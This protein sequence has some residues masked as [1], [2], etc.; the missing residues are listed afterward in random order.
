MNMKMYSERVHRSLLQ[1]ASNIPVF[2]LLLITLFI[3]LVGAG[4]CIARVRNYATE[5]EV[6]DRFFPGAAI[7]ERTIVLTPQMRK[8]V[9]SLTRRRFFWKKVR[10]H[11]A[12]K[13]GKVLGYAAVVNETG[14]TRKI[15]FM[16]LLDPTGEVKG[17]ELLVFRESQGYEIENPRW[18]RQFAGK[19]ID[20]PLR[21]NRDIVAISGATLSARAVTRGVKRVLAVFHVAGNLLR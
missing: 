4:S 3:L 9:E 6:L 18:R 13:E 11:I 1:G 5:D 21:L 20:D 14:K 7:E 2:R 17:V 12:R 19:T 8:E 16:V 15:T 10:F